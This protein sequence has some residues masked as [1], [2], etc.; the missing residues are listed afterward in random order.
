MTRLALPSWHPYS[1][2]CYPD[3]ARL[4]WTGKSFSFVRVHTLR[5]GGQHVGAHPP[6]ATAIWP[7]PGTFTTN[8][9]TRVSAQLFAR[10]ANF[11]GSQFFN[12]T[13]ICWGLG[14]F[15]LALTGMQETHTKEDMGEHSRLILLWGANFASQ[16]NT[17]RFVNAR[18]RRTPGTRTCYG[19][20]SKRHSLAAR[21]LARS[22]R[23]YRQ[24]IGFARCCC[25][26]LHIFCWTVNLQRPGGSHRSVDSHT[27]AVAFK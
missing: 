20:H 27:N 23:P 9:S 2:N 14:A 4:A 15:G 3:G 1:V 6:Q 17:A 10:F 24:C 19:A 11:H 25:R 21:W 16:P 12:P 18:P 26:P 7:G 8:Y 22:E 5:C 13:M